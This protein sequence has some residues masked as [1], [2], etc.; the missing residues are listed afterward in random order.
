[1]DAFSKR[2]GSKV[3]PGGIKCYCCAYG[4]HK[5]RKQFYVQVVRKEMKSHL[6]DEI[7]E[8]LWELEDMGRCRHW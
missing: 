3:G 4:K 7:Q 5:D 8:A 1:M 2:V 6:R